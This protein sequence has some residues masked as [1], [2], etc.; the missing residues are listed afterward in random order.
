MSHMFLLLECGK[1][2]EKSPFFNDATGVFFFGI[3]C[4]EDCPGN[5]IFLQQLK[6]AL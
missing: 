5:K 2:Y 3:L 1:G 4:L 6:A